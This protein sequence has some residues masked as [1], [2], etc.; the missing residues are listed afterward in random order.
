MR[1]WLLIGLALTV[2]M[3]VVLARAFWPLAP[4]KLVVSRQT[5]YYTA[6]LKADGTVDYVAAYNAEFA[7]TPGGCN[8][9]VP[10]IEALGP[11]ALAEETRELLTTRLQLH[12][13]ADRP[14]FVRLNDHLDAHAVAYGGLVAAADERA[15]TERERAIRETAKKALPKLRWAGTSL[16]RL[17][18]SQ[19]KQ[20]TAGP[21]NPEELPIV[22]DWIAANERVLN[23]IAAI[24]PGTDFVVPM[25]SPTNPP[26]VQLAPA[27]DAD[28]V[29]ELLTLFAA[30]AMLRARASDTMAACDD[31]LQMCRWGRLLSRGGSGGPPGVALLA[32]RDGTR[33]LRLIAQR[34]ELTAAQALDVLKRYE[35]LPTPGNIMANEVYL[36]RLALLGAIVQ[37]SQGQTVGLAFGTGGTLRP[38]AFDVNDVLRRTNALY[39]ALEVIATQPD[40]WQRVEISPLATAGLASEYA[41]LEKKMAARSVLDKAASLLS[42][43]T[44]KRRYVDDTLVWA[45]LQTIPI[46]SIVEADIETATN[47]DLTRA[48]LALAAYRADHGWYPDRLAELVPP[49]LAA[50]PVDAFTGGTL[51]YEGHVC[52]YRLWSVG[53]NGRDDGGDRKRDV[54]LATE[55]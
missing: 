20:A 21:W 33:L 42:S 14:R 50:E 15:E 55:E 34:E 30:R 54:V 7:E 11:A 35:A 22:A 25:V 28:T 12:F 3:A 16:E 41:S 13:A 4:V 46:A 8:R 52:G 10:F 26:T 17:A 6:P 44:A 47:A 45:V 27:V 5:T 32:R 51:C 9:A 53:R 1:K 36:R 23:G 24:E 39:D 43:S 18:D 37:L 49:Y 38:A 19:I 40:P 29:H 31:A 48:A 2:L